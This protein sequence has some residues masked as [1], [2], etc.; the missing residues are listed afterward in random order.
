MN[1]NIVVRVD[2]NGQSRPAWMDAPPRVTASSIEAL[3]KE[4]ERIL[5]LLEQKEEKN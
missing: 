5:C 4:K 2:I 3:R 1:A